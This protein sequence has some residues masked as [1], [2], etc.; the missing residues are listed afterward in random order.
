MFRHKVRNATWHPW[1]DPKSSPIYRSHSKGTPKF[2][3]PLHLSPFSAPDHGRKVDPPAL[4]RRGSRP[5]WR[6][7][8]WG[9][10]HEEIR[11]VASCWCHV[12]KDPDFSVLLLIRTRCPDTSSKAT[13]W[14]KALHEGALATLFIVRK[15]PQDPHTAPQLA[16]HP[17]NNER[18]KRSSLPQTRRG[19]SIQSQLCRHASI[20]V[21]NGEETWGS[22][23]NPRWGPLPLKQTQW[24]PE[25]PLPSPQ[26]PWLLIGI[27]RSS[28]RPPAKVEGNKGFLPQP[29][30]DLESPSSMCLE[31]RFPYHSSRA[32]M[33]SPSPRTWR[34]DFPGATREAPWAPRRTSCETP[35]WRRSSRKPTR[36][37]RH[38]EMRA[39]FSCMAWRAVPSPL[40]KLHRRLDSL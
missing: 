12:P 27:L 11:D 21:R 15:I 4:S 37:L 17:L 25:R 9:Q 3:A 23:L 18:G 19:L 22:C 38:R 6:T 33:R 39:I 40:S 2:L 14:M 35:H 8:G 30:K 26:Y 31:V 10:S 16:C 7:S 28:L 20:W 13:L 24:S 5:S 34:P 29:K 36:S 32:I 1:C